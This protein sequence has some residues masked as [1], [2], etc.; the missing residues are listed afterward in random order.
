VTLGAW[1]HLVVTVGPVSGGVQLTL[2]VDGA[3]AAQQTFPK[4]VANNSRPLRLAAGRTESTPIQYFPGTLDEIGF[5]NT[6]L[7]AARVSAH[8]TTGTTG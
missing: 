6:A 2:Y 8:Y 5:Y 7:S 3:Q 1:T 4:V